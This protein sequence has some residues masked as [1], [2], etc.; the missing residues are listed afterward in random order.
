M[1]GD[2]GAAWREAVEAEVQ[3]QFDRYEQA[4]RGHAIDALNDFFVDAPETTRFGI[5]EENYG[6][7][8]IDDYRRGCAPVH[9]HRQLRRSFV[10]AL[11]PQVVCVSS[12][13]TDPDTIGIGRQSQTWLRTPGGWKIAMAHVSVRAEST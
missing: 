8:A 4:L 5:G 9:P 3:Q 7:A 11:T 13:F 1:L 2:A 12:E 6:R 10:V